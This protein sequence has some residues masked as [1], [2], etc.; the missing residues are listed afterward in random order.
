MTG[1][2]AERFALHERGRIDVGAFADLVLF[3][4][5]RIIDRASFDEPTRI[6]DGIHGV[7]V[8]GCMAWDGKR[9]TGR[10]SGR[11]LTH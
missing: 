4:A 11:F 9:S 8:N 1:L 7:W 2:S 10:R 6:C 3:D 5:E